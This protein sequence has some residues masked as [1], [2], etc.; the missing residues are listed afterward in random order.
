MH[1]LVANNKAHTSTRMW[2]LSFLA[3]PFNKFL[4]KFV[5]L[6]GGGILKLTQNNSSIFFCKKAREQKDVGLSHIN[7]K[8]NI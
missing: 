2:P 1:F 8:S 7:H 4:S 3:T 6:A 5:I